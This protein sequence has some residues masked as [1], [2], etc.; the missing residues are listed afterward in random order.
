MAVNNVSKDRSGFAGLVI[1]VAVAIVMV[2]MMIQMRTL[3][4]PG[5]GY[6]KS[7]A[8]P[9]RPWLQDELL[10]PDDKLIKLPRPPK[11]NLDE[12]LSFTVP[13][14]RKDN[15]RGEITIDFATTGE[16]AGTWQCSYSHDNIDYI[17]NAAFEGNIDVSKEYSDK[18]GDDPSKLY[19]F[20]KGNYSQ[21]VYNRKSEEESFTEGLVYTT[22]WMDT[23]HSVSGKITITTDKSWS[24]DYKWRTQPAE[25]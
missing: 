5:M 23:D 4:R 14:T 13:V 17:Y 20:T 6:R 8:P 22:G 19:F 24:A 3:F 21:T 10:V 18:Q 1:L 7:T 12:P 15:D 16:V 11:P 2:L 9:S 25:L